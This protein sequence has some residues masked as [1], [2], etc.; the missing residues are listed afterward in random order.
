MDIGFDLLS[1]L[2]SEM[3][4]GIFPFL[5]F[6]ECFKVLSKEKLSDAVG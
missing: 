1:M 4:I 6:S 3:N 2:R 5:G